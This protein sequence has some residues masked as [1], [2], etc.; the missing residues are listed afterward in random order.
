ML[1]EAAGWD[2]PIRVAGGVGGHASAGTHGGLRQGDT[3]GKALAPHAPIDL[4]S[5]QIAQ[6]VIS[7]EAAHRA[8]HKRRNR[9]NV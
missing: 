6:P 5:E 8:S 3:A 4:L 2:R 7:D 1:A 9:Y